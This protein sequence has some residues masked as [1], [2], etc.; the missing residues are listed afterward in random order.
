MRIH[1]D[2]PGGA[3]GYPDDRSYGRHASGG[4]AG[5]PGSAHGY[6]YYDDAYSDAE[7][8]SLVASDRDYYYDDEAEPGLQPERSGWNAGADLGLLVLRWTL[9]GIFLAHGAQKLFGAFGGP[10]PEG[11]A[12]ALT[13]MGFQQSALLAL[14]TGGTELGAGAL[15]VLGLFTPL[16]AAGVLGVMASAIALNFGN[17]F[18]ASEGGVEFEVVLAALALGLMFTG[19]G[20]VALD[21]GRVWVRRPLIFGTVSLVI[22]AAASAAVL[23]LLR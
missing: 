10:G 11:F 8:T 12:G 4:A 3:G 19:P 21:R 9:G 6:D 16:A 5:G 1:D 22:A 14:I 15:L 17:G 7:A 20:R 13:G 18:F 2:R 23:L